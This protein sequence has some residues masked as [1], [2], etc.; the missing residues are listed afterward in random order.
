MCGV[1]TLKTSPTGLPPAQTADAS[2]VYPEGQEGA[3]VT[4]PQCELASQKPLQH[5][6]EEVQALPSGEQLPPSEL[7]Q[8]PLMQVG[9]TRQLAPPVP[10]AAGLV[11][12]WH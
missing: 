1:T 7:P 12:P 8:T 6:N 5:C 4:G 3:Q 10:H 9:Q 2:H 11:P